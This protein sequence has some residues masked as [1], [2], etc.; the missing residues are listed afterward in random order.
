MRRKEKSRVKHTF[1]E[2]ISERLDGILFAMQSEATRW[3]LSRT[4][5]LNRADSKGE[6]VKK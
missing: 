2:S 4:R 5:L 6:S 3:F 1:S